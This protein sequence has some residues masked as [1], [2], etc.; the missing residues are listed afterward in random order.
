MA[1]PH[2]ITAF[3]RQRI[4]LVDSSVF[5]VHKRFNEWRQ[6]HDIVV[7]FILSLIFE[8]VWTLRLPL[9]V[10]RRCVFPQEYEGFDPPPPSGGTTNK[11]IGLRP[12]AA[13]PFWGY[14]VKY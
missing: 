2:F 9:V 11:F 5:C 12:T 6:L 3:T 1:A 8:S 4:L 7:F 10:H 14:R 13:G